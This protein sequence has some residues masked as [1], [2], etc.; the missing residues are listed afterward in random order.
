MKK[1]TL[2]RRIAAL[3]E[4]VQKQQSEINLLVSQ[5]GCHLLHPGEVVQSVLKD[6][7]DLTFRANLGKSTLFEST[8]ERKQ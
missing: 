4:V 6:S 8:V 3:E 1:K 7:G 5:K 2:E